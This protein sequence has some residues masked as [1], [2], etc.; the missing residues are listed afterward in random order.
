MLLAMQKEYL[1]E[2]GDAVVAVKDDR[3]RV[4]LNQLFQPV[5]HGAVSGML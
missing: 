3:G 4:K 2:L 1:I 5:A